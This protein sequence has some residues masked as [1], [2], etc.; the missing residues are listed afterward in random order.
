M[1][2]IISSVLILIMLV[3]VC[4]CANN[5]QSSLESDSFITRASWVSEVAKMF[6]M[7]ECI[8]QTPY[9]EDVD[10]SSD[11]FTY[12]QS[13][14]EWGAISTGTTTFNPDEVAT[15]GFATCSAVMILTGGEEGHTNEEMINYAVEIGLLSEEEKEDSLNSGLTSDRAN[16]LVETTKVLYFAE[17]LEIVNEV[18]LNEEVEDY[19]NMAEKITHVA[20]NEY[21]VAAELADSISVED[22]ITVPSTDGINEEIALKVVEATENADGSLTVITEQP[23]FEEVFEYVNISGTRKVTHKDFIPEEGVTVVPVYDEADTVGFQ[24]VASDEASVN[25]EAQ[26]SIDSKNK[27][28]KSAALSSNAG[29][30]E[31]KFSIDENGDVKVSNTEANDDGKMT[32][33]CYIPDSEQALLKKV[34]EAF[35][36]KEKT[37]NGKSTSLIKDYMSG[38]VSKESLIKQLKANAYEIS[39]KSHTPYESGWKITGKIT[40]NNIMITPDIKFGEFLGQTNFADFKKATIQITGDA[41]VEVELEGKIDCEQKI[42]SMPIVVPGTGATINLEVYLYIETNGK[43]AIKYGIDVNNK[44]ELK[45]GA[46]IKHVNDSELTSNSVEASVELEAGYYFVGTVY[47]LGFDV[48]SL[49]LKAGVGVSADAEIKVEPDVTVTEDKIKYVEKHTLVSNIDVYMP[50]ISLEINKTKGNVLGKFGLSAT[51]TISDKKMIEEGTFPGIYQGLSSDGAFETVLFTIER[52]FDIVD[53][54]EITEGSDY[55]SF[56][57]LAINMEPGK[58]E[59]LILDS[60]PLG[61][62]VEDIIWSSTNTDVVSVIA[63]KVEAKAEGSAIITAQTSDG[64]YSTT[65]VIQVFKE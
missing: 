6:G 62:V 34:N 31:M 47:L 50:L 63:G 20:D 27:I 40:F 21:I 45:K 13:C 53:E 28:K 65:C 7:T 26:I 2:R 60:I 55:L 1:K 48:L 16:T 11:I 59:E 8:N 15:L 57:K 19:G 4:G 44:V 10:S 41:T 61:Y 12:V 52:E 23:E 9:F 64:K 30:D 22:I 51:Y 3:Q 54:K 49:K 42:G 36:I 29:D 37:I 17:N 56:E 5:K 58:S 46:P 25:F 35:G 32:V 38:V 14:Y 18:V 43:L 39:M 33:E 24:T